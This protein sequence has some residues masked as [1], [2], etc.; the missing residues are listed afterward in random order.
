MTL[1]TVSRCHQVALVMGVTRPIRHDCHLV[2]GHDGPH[3]C[4][5]CEKRWES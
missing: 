5:L 3:E 2:A 4:Y 1:S